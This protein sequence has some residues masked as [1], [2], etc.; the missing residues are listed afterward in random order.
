MD[1]PKPSYATLGRIS[2]IAE[3]ALGFE[4]IKNIFEFGARYGE[5]SVEFAKRY[6][7]ANIY[8]F[9]CNENTLEQCKQNTSIF[10]NIILTPKAVSDN[11]GIITFYP[12]DKDKTITTWEDGN[13]GASSLLKASGKYEVEQYVQKETQIQCI[14][15]DSFMKEHNIPSIDILWMDIQG[16]ELMALKGLG[17]RLSDVHVIQCEVE[18]I[19]IYNEQPLFK[20]IKKH[21]VSHG[22]RF[23]GFSSKSKYSGDAIFIHKDNL[24]PNCTALCKWL[25][26]PNISMDDYWGRTK[27]KII[28]RS[29]IYLHKIKRFGDTFHVHKP[30]NDYDAIIDWERKIFNPLIGKDVQFRCSV[31]D[32]HILDVV[33][34]TTEKDLIVL[35]HCID[36][37]R[38][39]LKH[40]LGNIYIVS[41]QNDIIKQI[42]NEKK[43]IFI[44]ET[45]VIENLSKED[46]HYSVNGIDR[47][48]WLFQQLLKL[49]VDTFAK[50]E[51][52]L[53]MDSDTILVHPVKY[54]HK[55]KT[56]L[57]TSDEHYETY[58][59]VYRNLMKENPIS[60][61]S[62]IAHGMLFSKQYLQEMKQFIS[63]RN[64]KNW[65]EA[66]LNN[67]DYSDPSGF[68]EYETYGNY[69]LQHHPT[70]VK[71]E[72]WF[73]HSV[74][75][76]EETNDLP[77]YI[78]TASLHSYNR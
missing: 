29:L 38:R 27:I 71:L 64:Q 43:C 18:M 74:S 77:R 76:L 41:P 56:I 35:E 61:K 5:D 37:I 72:Y 48:G 75:K 59:T 34:P 3:S 11:N 20:E 68:S 67:V 73:N 26:V 50:H 15:L 8:S 14:R 70:K 54:L 24:T 60:P 9:E 46:I 66:I 32:S 16:A 44:G 31:K 78:K 2:A 55:E 69:L 51:H 53:V 1:T 57:N 13:Q 52:I 19:E 40:P 12:I 30:G 6:S 7:N 17:S 45:N 23:M 4:Y 21:L 47:S 28:N 25:L 58:F 33:I 10:P 62:F 42:V 65:A 36:S 39:F 63:Q 49:S 22:F